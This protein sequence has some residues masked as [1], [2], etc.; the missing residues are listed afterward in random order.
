M[1][2]Y[3]SLYAALNPAT[4]EGGHRG[5]RVRCTATQREL[6]DIWW[7]AAGSTVTWHW[8]TGE[9]FGERTTERNAVQALR[10]VANARAGRMALPRR[11]VEDDTPPVERPARAARPSAPERTAPPAPSAPTPVK[12]IEW[13]TGGGTFDVTAAMAK[14]LKDLKGR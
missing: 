4:L 7:T 5:S 2:S 10:D 8:R 12:R 14:G 6:G 1:K 3:P 11:P 13:G 9:A